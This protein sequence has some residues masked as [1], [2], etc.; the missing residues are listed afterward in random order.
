MGVISCVESGL[1]GEAHPASQYCM[2][3]D[4]GEG[5]PSGSNSSEKLTNSEAAAS[6]TVPGSDF[7][8]SPVSKPRQISDH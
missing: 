8:D 3:N 4:P 6:I 2:N 5:L 7:D 1:T